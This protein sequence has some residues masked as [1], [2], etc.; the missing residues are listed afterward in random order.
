M[1][2]EEENE[3]L[4][5]MTMK[6]RSNLRVAL[7][8]DSLFKMAGGERV[9]E[10][11]AQM[12]PQ[13]DIFTLFSPPA[14]KRKK[15]LSE[16]IL[17]HKIYTSALGRWPFISHYYRYTLPF[18]PLYIEKFDFSQYDLVISSSWSVAH[19]IVTPL[20]C[21]HVTYVNTP[22]R[23]AWDQYSKYF[24]KKRGRWKYS[25]FFNSLRIWDSSVSS[26]ADLMIANSNFVSDRMKK[27]WDREAD[28]VIFP[29]VSKYSGEIL[30][31]R[32]SYFVAGA[33]FEENKGGDFLF[34]CAKWIG[35][36]LKVIGRGSKKKFF[37][38]KYRNCKNIEFLGWIDE[39]E[40]FDILSKASGYIMTG[41][42]DFG[43]FPVEALSCGTPVLAYGFGGILDT[44]RNNENGVLFFE[45][46][47]DSFKNALLEFKNR[48]WN[49]IDVAKSVEGMNS[50]EDFRKK[51]E[52]F[53][54]DNG[55]NI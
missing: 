52:A 7:V 54:V 51:V 19:G 25:F 18:W 21:K 20:E 11:F 4:L 41:V 31:K 45:Q 35:F 5:S 12:F 8:I 42:E 47:I 34:E 24:S 28:V 53:L 37:E 38:K 46:T 13:A 48:K 16:E 33:P 36:N 40:K 50:G 44:V 3:Q 22:M 26:R 23:Y 6:K 9:L 14:R 32:S 17:S 10:S 15:L 30:L 27:Y 49:Y 43:I 55:I 1:F 39:K 29:P 2:T